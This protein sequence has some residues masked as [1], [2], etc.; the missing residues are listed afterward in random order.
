MTK[1]LH[2]IAVSDLVKNKD[3]PEHRHG[4]CRARWRRAGFLVSGSHVFS[5][6]P[7]A[8]PSLNRELSHQILTGR[9]FLN[10]NVGLSPGPSPCM[11]GGNPE[12]P[13]RAGR[14]IPEINY[15]PYQK[16][17]SSSICFEKLK[18]SPPSPSLP[19][20]N[21]QLNPLKKQKPSKIT[22]KAAIQG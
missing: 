21:R 10:C 19:L 13:F 6:Q 2:I 5:A 12:E 15:S 14:T 7:A 17:Q 4:D 20:P 8:S 3:Y 11:I 22:T 18:L 9:C 1:H 16:E